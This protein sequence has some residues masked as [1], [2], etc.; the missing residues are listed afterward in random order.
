MKRITGLAAAALLAGCATEA[1][2]PTARTVYYGF[3]RETLTAEAIEQ[4]AALQDDAAETGAAS[5]VIVAHADTVADNE[6]NQALSERRA[7]TI[8]RDLIARGVPPEDIAIVGLGESAL[9]VETADGVMEPA[10]RFATVELGETGAREPFDRDR[11]YSFV[12]P[13]EQ[14]DPRRPLTAALTPDSDEAAE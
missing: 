14:P 12:L 9:A 13:P 1:P 3:D 8:R 11:P 10:N 7:R 4:L 5:V 6:I 2:E